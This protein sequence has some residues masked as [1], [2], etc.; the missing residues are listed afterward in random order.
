VLSIEKND[1]PS[2]QSF[3]DL[4]VGPLF[5]GEVGSNQILIIAGISDGMALPKHWRQPFDVAGQ[6][7]RLL[8]SVHA[9]QSAGQFWHIPEVR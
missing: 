2:A 1:N 7:H 9:C 5:N 6:L 4:N 3:A 8:S